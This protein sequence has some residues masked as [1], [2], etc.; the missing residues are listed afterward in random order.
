MNKEELEN[1]VPSIK[2]VKELKPHLL[3]LYIVDDYMESKEKYEAFIDRI[4]NIIKGC[5]TIKECRTYPVKFKFYKEDTAVHTLELRMF[6]INLFAWYPFISLYGVPNILSKYFII[7]DP[8]DLI[9]IEDYI[10]YKIIVTLRN[11]NVKGTILNEYTAEVLH[12]M[13]SICLNFSIIMNLNFSYFTFKEIYDKNPKLR[14]IMECKFT[15]DMQP[16]DIEEFMDENQKTFIES[17]IADPTNPI[18]IILKCRTGIKDKQLTEFS[19]AQSLKPTLDGKIIPIPIE[20]STLIRGLDRPSY[21]YIDATGARKSL[22]M[23]K[24]VMG[25]LKRLMD[26]F[27]GDTSR[28]ITGSVA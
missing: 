9:T 10:N 22:V 16:N 21:L 3:S 24:T 6:L 8:D 25:Q 12:Y 20:N 17:L 19:I 5:F 1:E 4:Y 23:N 18:G 11:Y 14:K 13:S 15:E 27:C 26:Y 2:S 7:S 28:L